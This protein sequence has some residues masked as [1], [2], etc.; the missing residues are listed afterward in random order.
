M[1]RF[2]R[3]VFL[4]L[5]A[6]REID[7]LQFDVADNGRLDELLKKGWHIVQITAAGDRGG[8]Y[9]LIEREGP[10]AGR[11]IPVPGT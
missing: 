3:V 9:A 1:P 11:T 5:N 6:G 2:Q 8:V 10:P 7:G 4:P